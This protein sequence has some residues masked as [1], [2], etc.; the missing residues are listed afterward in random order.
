[1]WQNHSPNCPVVN[2][3]NQ[4]FN[5]F[6]CSNNVSVGK[7]FLQMFYQIPVSWQTFHKRSFCLTKKFG[8]SNFNFFLLD[9]KQFLPKI[10]R[11]RNTAYNVEKDRFHFLILFLK[12][13]EWSKDNHSFQNENEN[14]CTS[15]KVTLWLSSAKGLWLSKLMWNVSFQL[16]CLWFS[17]ADGW[18][19]F[20]IETNQTS[21]D[22]QVRA[23]FEP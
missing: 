3:V 19:Q 9:L 22:E 10:V 23:G 15:I 11:R 13:I 4:I 12:K 18:T 21:F 20:Y 8:Y 14:I 1:M 7:I 16:R 17:S 5:G 6:E 2:P